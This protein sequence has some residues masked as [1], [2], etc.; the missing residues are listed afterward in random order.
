[1]SQINL[2]PEFIDD[3]YMDEI[4]FPEKWVSDYNYIQGRSRTP[5]YLKPKPK[6]YKI[7]YEPPTIITSNPDELC[8][9][10]SQIP[11]NCFEP[12]DYQESVSVKLSE[13]EYS[14]SIASEYLEILHNKNEDNFNILFNLIFYW[15]VAFLN[16]L[17]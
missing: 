1:M 12:S 15:S 8:M 5:P 6:G 14:E 2:N 10:P 9:M 16:C 7:K 17:F 11:L 13:E 4:D 3:D